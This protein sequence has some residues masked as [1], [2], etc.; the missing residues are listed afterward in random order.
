M[1]IRQKPSKSGQWT[2]VPIALSRTRVHAGVVAIMERRRFLTGVSAAVA[3]TAVFSPYEYFID[4]N[5][6]PTP[7]RALFDGWV[8]AEFRIYSTDGRFVDSARLT[9]I[10]DAKCC[11]QLEQFSVVFE[12]VRAESLPEGLFRLAR[13]TGHVMDIAL[14]P[15]AGAS[16]RHRAVF[17][18]LSRA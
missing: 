6:A 18:L 7:T 3:W 4:R 15:I 17:S 10:E 9:E 12:T 8:G 13:P 16:R 2:G 14:S 1:G 5:D 11:E